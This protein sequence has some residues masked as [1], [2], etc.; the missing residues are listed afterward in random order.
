MRSVNRAAL[1]ADRRITGLSS[2]VLAALVAEVGPQ[3]QARQDAKLADRPHRLRAVGAGAEHKLIFVDRLLA[4]LVHR[5]HGVTHD[6]LAARF[7]VHRSTVTR[8]IGE[9]RPL[10]AARGCTVE[11]GVRLRT[12]ADVVAYLGAVPQRAVLDATDVRVRRPAAHRPGRKRF[13]SAKH[14]QHTAKAMVL[15]DARGQLLFVGE[16]RPGSTH[17]LTQ[18]RQSGLVE[19]LRGRGRSGRGDVEILADKGYQGLQ[20]QSDFAVRT[21]MPTRAWTRRPIPEWLVAE[22]DHARHAHSSA[23]M[24][25]EHGIAHL[26]NWRVLARHL[27]RREVVDDNFRAVA[28]LA[29]SQQRATR[30]QQRRRPGEPLALPAGPAAA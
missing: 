25:V 16:V 24:A 12:V 15:T 10:L 27:G 1:A 29:S 17:D 2:P 13:V 23:R 3:W 18:V 4:T 9:V 8:A 26:K 5:R 21:P 19:L 20:R 11:D 30:P 14:R 7:G 6:V 28:G 22:H